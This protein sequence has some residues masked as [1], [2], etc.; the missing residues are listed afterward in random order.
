MRTLKYAIL[1][2]IN[3]PQA[4]IMILLRHLLYLC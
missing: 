3:R 2:L 1:G 4:Q